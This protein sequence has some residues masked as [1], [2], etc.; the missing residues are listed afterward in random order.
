MSNTEQHKKKV[1]YVIFGTFCPLDRYT[2]CMLLHLGRVA[3]YCDEYVCVCVSVC[4]RLSARITRKAHSQTS[5]KFLCMLPM[6]VARSSYD[7]V[8]ICYVLPVLWMTSCF[9]IMALCRIMCIPK[10]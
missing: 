2:K 10:W 5:L 6:A 8:A 7:G 9:H 4:V 1:A 3:K